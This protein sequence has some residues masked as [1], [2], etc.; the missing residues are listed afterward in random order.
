M[1]LCLVEKYPLWYLPIATGR[2]FSQSLHRSKYFSGGQSSKVV[3]EVPNIEETP[4]Q[5]DGEPMITANPVVIEIDP[6]AL[7]VMMPT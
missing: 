4:V 1:D 7:N 5:I 3:V 6:L 2:L